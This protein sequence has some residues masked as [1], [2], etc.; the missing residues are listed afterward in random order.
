MNN[1]FKDIIN[2]IVPFVMLG[3]AI[4]LIAGFAILFS[5]F[6]FWG[7]LIGIIL[8]AAMSVK[9]FFFPSKT[10]ITTKSHI[11]IEG[12]VIEHKNDHKNKPK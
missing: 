9:E 3:I 2:T 1:S 7:V 10:R 11:I 6:L 4:A 8:W 5:Y 12:Q